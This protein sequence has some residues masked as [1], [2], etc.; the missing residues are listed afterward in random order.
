[1]IPSAAIAA[2]IRNVD[3]ES[4]LSASAIALYPCTSKGTDNK[5]E[6]MKITNKMVD[7]FLTLKILI[8]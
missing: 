8:N 4:A 3:K 1:M 7:I 2:G 6:V 5:K